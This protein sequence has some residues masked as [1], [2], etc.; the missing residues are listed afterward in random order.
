MRPSLGWE[1]EMLPRFPVENLNYF[2]LGRKNENKKE[3]KIIERK[4]LPWCPVLC[5][6][7]IFSKFY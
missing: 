6:P 3:R 5:L 7:H 2:I 4:R 1:N